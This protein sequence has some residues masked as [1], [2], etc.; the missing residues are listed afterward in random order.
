MEMTM[1]SG[2]ADPTASLPVAYSTSTFPYNCVVLIETRNSAGYTYQGSGVIIGPHTILTASHMLWDSAHQVEANQVW[3]YP[4][5]NGGFV[6]SPG[7]NNPI[8]GTTTWHNY[9]VGVPYSDP[10]SMSKSDSQYDF[11]VIDTSY[12]FPTYM[13]AL[14][15][16]GSGYV[17]MTGYPAYNHGTQ[18]DTYNAY[19]S[20][21]SNYSILDY[22]NFSASP[23]NSG[24]PLWV[25]DIKSVV[26]IVSTSGWAAQLT[27]D[28]WLTIL[29]WEE[30]DSYLWGGPTRALA[31]SGAGDFNNNGSAD[32]VWSTSYYTAMW[33]Y[34]PSAQQVTTT[35]LNINSSGWAFFGSGHFSSANGS[36]A[37]ASQML[38][39]YTPNGTMALWWADSSG[40]MTGINLGQRWINVGIISAGQFTKSSV[41]N[42]V[43]DFLVYN[44]ADH[45]LYDW[46]IT[47]QNQL[48]G[49]DITATSG[50]PWA[51]VSLVTAGQFTANGGT[52]FLVS[53][54][55][56]HHLYDWWIGANNTL[57]GIDL[58]PYWSNVALVGAGQFTASAGTNFLVTNTIDHHLYDWWIAPNNTLTGVDLGPVWANVQLVTAGRFD[59]RTTNTELLVQN[60][61]DHHLYEW[62]ITPQGQ[63]T[64]IDLGPHW[65]NV[66]LIGNSHYNN[67]SAFNELLVRNTSDGHFYE[68]W[69]A[70]N[71]LTGV[72]LGASPS[73]SATVADN[74]SSA[75]ASSGFT[76]AGSSITVAN[77]GT[78][79]AVAAS[80]VAEE[81]AAVGAGAGPSRG[82]QVAMAGL[83]ATASVAEAS[84][85]SVSA[86]STSLLVQSMASFGASNAVA[87]STAALLGAG[88]V[89]QSEIAAP[90][91]P[92]LAH[93]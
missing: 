75:V 38:M 54:N 23:G 8:T 68:W 14:L 72:D 9:I 77:S 25:D 62:W 80:G 83:P 24:G 20:K 26:G 93:V 86:D 21:D 50:V 17:H 88:P 78:G 1:G 27:V 69:I 10:A 5:W 74:S 55:A 48:T 81:V 87:D 42:N 63:L 44:L 18:T 33:Q 7:T 34:N 30:M 31:V 16:Y 46:W 11:G 65:I 15:E 37:G 43:N 58:G 29:N 35:N 4:A 90:T 6:P 57:Q 82:G 61:I 28:K 53:N 2:F 84:L 56:D 3:L 67:N 49:F 59:N 71:Q 76:V 32:F 36:N 19:V 73:T 66:Q 45:H 79:A 85:S 52:N 64:G 12:T 13:N 92:H 47:P 60:T 91:D 70:N 40:H 41:T 89:Q 51:N 39:D 22:Q